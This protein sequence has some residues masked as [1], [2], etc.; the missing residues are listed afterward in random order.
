MA[1]IFCIYTL[2]KKNEQNRE[3][4][5]TIEQKKNDKIHPYKQVDFE[6]SNNNKKKQLFCMAD[7]KAT[8]QK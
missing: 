2:I 4:K 1:S 3:K 5:R 8:F 7:K 6:S